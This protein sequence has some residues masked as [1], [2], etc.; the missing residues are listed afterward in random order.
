[1]DT[2]PGEITAPRPITKEKAKIA[3]RDEGSTG[4]SFNQQ[5]L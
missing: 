5:A 2:G 3:A 1:V 4:L